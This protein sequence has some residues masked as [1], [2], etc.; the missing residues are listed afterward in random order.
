[1]DLTALATTV[2]GI[3]TPIIANK[4]VQEFSK[5]IWNK[6]QNWFIIDNKEIEELEDL[7]KNPTD[8]DFEEAFIS[9]IKTKL[10][11]DETLR[12]E[13][14]ELITDGEK[15]GDEQTKIFIKNSKNFVIG[16]ISNVQNVHI[17][18]N[19]GTQKKDN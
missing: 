14:E 9:K 18:D 6:I 4:D 8:K 7:K 13:I 12:N 15:N 5:K 10:K 19:L 1:M 16:N 17:G 2:F 3:V 11:K